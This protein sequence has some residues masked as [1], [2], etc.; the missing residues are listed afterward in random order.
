MPNC[1]SLVWRWKVCSWHEPPLLRRIYLT[2][3]RIEVSYSHDSRLIET[4][5]IRKSGNK[6]TQN[7]IL[8]LSSTRQ[9]VRFNRYQKLDSEI[10]LC[11]CSAKGTH[12]IRCKKYKQIPVRLVMRSQS[13]VTYQTSIGNVTSLM[14]VD[15]A[16]VFSCYKTDDSDGFCLAHL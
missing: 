14:S 16:W 3:R 10:K 4:S 6:T 1:K 15:F 5:S 7:V 9:P 13:Y 2:G 11:R 8:E 12:Q